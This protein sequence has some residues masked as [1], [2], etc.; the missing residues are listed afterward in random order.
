MGNK[1][2]NH[3]EKKAISMS[4]ING[5]KRSCPAAVAAASL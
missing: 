5:L 4:C 3:R 2:P 1:G